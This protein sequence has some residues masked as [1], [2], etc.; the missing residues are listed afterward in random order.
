MRASSALIA[1]VALAGFGC[2]A[3]WTRHPLDAPEPLPVRQQVQVWHGGHA[4]LLHGLKIDSTTVSGIPYHRPLNCDSCVVVIPRA[5][6]DSLRI[7]D[8]SNGLWKSVALVGGVII[9]SGIIYCLPR[10]CYI[11]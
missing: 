5:E 2:G 9:V 10:D 8:L 6:V 1:G 7:G 11:D 4:S 3:G